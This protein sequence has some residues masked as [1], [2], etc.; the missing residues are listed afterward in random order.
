MDEKKYDETFVKNTKQIQI[1][2][3]ERIKDKS[4]EPD[5]QNRMKS[6]ENRRM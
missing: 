2:T 5:D 4:R 6:V 3:N 1:E